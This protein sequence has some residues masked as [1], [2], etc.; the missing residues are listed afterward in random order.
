[1]PS[2]WFAALPLKASA[3]ETELFSEFG[4]TIVLDQRLLLLRHTVAQL[5]SMRISPKRAAAIVGTALPKISCAS[6]SI[7]T[8]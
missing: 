1:M 4:G 7:A 8:R 6:K 2:K 5:Y 3:L